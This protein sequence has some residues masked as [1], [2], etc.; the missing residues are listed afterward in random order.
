MPNRQFNVYSPLVVVVPGEPFNWVCNSAEG[1]QVTVESEDGWPLN[2]DPYTVTSGTPAPATVNSGAA[3]GSY[4]FSCNPTAPN[5]QS[6]ALVVAALDFVSPCSDV[7][8]MPSEY[9]IWVNDTDQALTIEPDPGNEDFWPFD[10]QSHAVVAH[11]YLAVQIPPDAETGKTY[12]LIVTY[13][14]GG[15][16][17][18]ATQPKLIVGSGEF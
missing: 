16:C 15:G 18:Q 17:T 2:Q 12:N 5:V 6:Q 13:E 9:F 11:G 10:S 14:G 4:G 8:V 1:T 3:A 7:T